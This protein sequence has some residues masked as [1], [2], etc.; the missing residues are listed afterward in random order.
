M[1]KPSNSVFIYVLS[2]IAAL[3]GL[4][5]GYDTGMISGAILFIRKEF[6]LTPAIQGLV[7][8]SVLIGAFFG[9]LLSGRLADHYGRRKM[10]IIVAFIFGIGA[11]GA[12]LAPNVEWLIAARILIGAAIGVSSYNAP[13]YISEIAPTKNRGALVSLNQLA[14]TCGIVVGYFAGYVFADSG[15]WRLMI[16]LEAIPAVVLI[17]G[18]MFLPETPRWLV[19]RNRMHEAKLVLE[20]IRH[21]SDVEG[22]L[23]SIEL[24]RLSEPKGAWKSITEPWVKRALMVG[25]GLAFF[26]QL[27]GINAVLYYAPTIFQLSGFQSA[28][29][30]LSATLGIGIV[31]MLMTIVALKLLDRWGRRP[32]LFIGLTGM[33]ISLLVLATAFLM[34]QIMSSHHWIAIASLMLFVA[35]F[36]I[37]LGPIFW[38]IISEIYPLDIRGLAMGL[39]TM[40]NWGF[41]L[42]VALTF[43]TLVSR[44]GIPLTL[45]L[46]A[47]ISL[48]ALFFCYFMVPETKGRSLEDIEAQLRRSV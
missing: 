7:V 20:R 19:N 26:Q 25:I 40:A 6:S 16:G 21:P 48:S 4:M 2:F 9:A 43:L 1:E 29:A 17:A 3:A 46:Y 11:L 34:P 42:I 5:Y 13:L 41:N 22:E 31:N 45:G 8:S 36:A 27:T 35:S 28:E 14:I 15:Q 39:S 18:M 44:I 47:L 32:L 23:A 10:I 30:S 38:L 12:A 24:T 33:V 37:S